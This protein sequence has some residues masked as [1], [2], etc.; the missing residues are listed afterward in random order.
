[1]TA[2]ELHKA[3]MVRA[4][5]CDLSQLAGNFPAARSP[6]SWKP[7]RTIH[8]CRVRVRRSS[9]VEY[10]EACAGLARLRWISKIT[11]EYGSCGTRPAQKGPIVIYSAAQ[12]GHGYWL[13]IRGAERAPLF[14][15]QLTSGKLLPGA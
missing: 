14:W 1:M 8:P 15:G 13:E 5:Q 4:F 12:P 6:Q 7:A 11:T 3:R 10:M 9:A 2:E